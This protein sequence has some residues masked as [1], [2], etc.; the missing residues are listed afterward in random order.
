MTRFGAAAGPPRER[1]SSTAQGRRRSPR[2]SAAFHGLAALFTLTTSLLGAESG[3]LVVPP[4]P[5]AEYE[6]QAVSLAADY[7]TGGAAAWWEKLSRHSPLRALGREEALREIEVRTGPAAGA[8]W[9]FRT[10]AGSVPPGTVMFS[11]SSPSGLD[12]T[13]VL[14]LIEEGGAFRIHSVRS[15]SEPNEP[16]PPASPAEKRPTRAASEGSFSIPLLVFGFVLSAAAFAV[17]YLARERLVPALGAAGAGLL[18]LVLAFI[19][20]RAPKAPPA[21]RLPAPP[22]VRAPGQ[23]SD[24]AALASLLS[25]RQKLEAGEE[26]D[27]AALARSLPGSGAA[28]DVSRLWIAQKA[29]Q[30]SN[31]D[32]SRKILDA[33]PHPDSIP[34][35]ALLRARMAFIDRREIDTALAYEKAIGA[36]PLNDGLLFE[37]AQAFL[38]LGFESQAKEYLT[39]LSPFGSRMADV[40]YA[41]SEQAVRDRR[42][43]DAEKSFLYAWSL[44]PYSRRELFGF[45]GFSELYMRPAVAM[46]LKLSSPEEPSAWSSVSAAGPLGG[47]QLAELQATSQI[48]RAKTQGAEFVP[49]PGSALAEAKGSSDGLGAREKARET[50]LLLR[51]SKLLALAPTVGSLSQPYLRNEILETVQALGRRHR[52]RELAQLTA[53]FGG[54]EPQVPA[55]ILL[56]RAEALRRTGRPDPCRTLLFDLAGNEAFLRR[57]N[58]MQLYELGEA[59][60]ALSEYDRAIKLFE[61]ASVKWHTELLEDRIRQ[62]RTEARL[63]GSNQTHSS[64]HFEIQCPPDRDPAFPTEMASVLEAERTRLLKWIPLETHRPIKV[65]LLW[66]DEFRWNYGAGE[67]LGLYDGKIRVPLAE[68]QRFSPNVVAILTHELAHA[69]IAEATG[70]RA[71]HWFQEGLAQHV[72]M[73]RFR[74]NH[75]PDYDRRGTLLA[76]PVIDEALRSFPDPQMTEVAYEECDWTIGFI[77]TRW[78]V[79]GIHRILEAFH[80]GATTEEALPRALGVSVAAFQNLFLKWA[81]HEA[82]KMVQANVIRYDLKPEDESIRMGNKRPTEVEPEKKKVV[83]PEYLREHE[84][85]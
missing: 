69:M 36:G 41:L 65:D 58:P 29:L 19:G 55:E 31:L 1:G 3:P 12:D 8:R 7:L 30:E 53:N 43:D 40:H 5:L 85:K 14:R 64:T 21:P 83:I 80:D 20:G 15:L 82:P 37:A 28:A 50:A 10:P 75:L 34:R 33:I 45:E 47:D 18:G 67:I 16:P 71:P 35:V 68:V 11:V 25:L 26:K 4:R 72:E 48:L 42:L 81:T 32:L 63:A 13:I 60:V 59:F 46:A 84:F 54:K 27:L 78:G 52:W 56:L 73:R 57:N 39:R 51:A 6:K 70:D 76:L 44:R 23:A 66:I 24:P 74:A 2:R 77:E 17:A 61:K 22:S 79:E 62:V 49:P 38:Q 9:E